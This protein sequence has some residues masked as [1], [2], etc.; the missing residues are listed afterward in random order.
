MKS[1]HLDER[2][3]DNEDC[4]NQLHYL[5]KMYLRFKHLLY[6]SYYIGRQFNYSYRLYPIKKK[7]ESISFRSYELYNLHGRD[8]LLS[9]M[10]DECE[11]EEIIFDIGAS[12]GTYSLALASKYPGSDILAFEPN[13]ETFKKL[14]K[15]IECNGF[16]NITIHNIGISDLNGE[17]SF[18][19]STYP[20]TS[21]FNR[22]SSER[23]GGRVKSV[24]RVDVRRLDTVVEETK[25]C[26]DRIKFDVEGH[27]LKVLKGGKKTLEGCRPVIYMERHKV[28]TEK[29]ENE[30][31]EFLGIFN[32][33]IDKRDNKIWI[34]HPENSKE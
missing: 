9:M 30:L 12:I 7:I 17:K 31:E 5:D 18:Y 11:S 27:G 1:G 19:I 25:K 20:E 14:E 8:E 32:Y 2:D 23:W 13:L 24:K 33:S 22:K 26:P 10:L 16:N 29:N 6:S 34:C 28:G 21:S 15:N 4:N 3:S